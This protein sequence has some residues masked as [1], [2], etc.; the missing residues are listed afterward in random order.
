MHQDLFFVV[1][2]ICCFGLGCCSS[3]DR[4][5]WFQSCLA[6]CVENNCTNTEGPARGLIWT[7]SDDCKYE[8]MWSTVETFVDN[9]MGV[10]QFYGKW[11]FV[12][13]LGLQ[14]PASAIF[15]ILN[16]LG[17]VLMLRRFT[18]LV[19]RHAPLFWLWITYSL[20]C[21]N[22]WLWSTVFHAKD[23]DLTEKLDYF[24][25]FS[26]VLFSFYSA[27]I[28]FFGPQLSWPTVTITLLCLGFMIYHIF[29]LSLV[30]FDYGYNMRANILVGAVNVT[31]WLAWCHQQRERAAHVWK[32]AATVVLVSVS[33]L[34]E[35]ADFPPLA[36]TLD[37]HALWHLSTCP[38][39]LLWYSF[40]IDDCLYQLSQKK[41]Q[42]SV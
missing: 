35:T 3:G 23:T 19:P 18:S 4:S 42:K 41:L 16:L 6:N 24:C 15:S 38:L 8:C 39:P 29:Y 32:C 28:R 13:W 11:P 25:A 20:V 14:E 34:L 2:L 30:M 40:L 27:C 31:A 21:I 33:V 26:M 37:A 10:P 5:H 12:Q 22:A 1:F 17:H 9:G 7:C 36:W